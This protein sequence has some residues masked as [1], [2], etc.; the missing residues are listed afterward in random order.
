MRKIEAVT[1]SLG[2][3]ALPLGLAGA[4]IARQLTLPMAKDDQRWAAT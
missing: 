4:T 1:A 2:S 3:V